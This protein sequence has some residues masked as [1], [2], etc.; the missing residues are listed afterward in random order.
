MNAANHYKLYFVTGPTNGLMPSGHKWLLVSLLIEIYNIIRHHYA[1]MF[2]LI[3]AV[4]SVRS[5]DAIN[6]TLKISLLIVINRMDNES[7]C[8]SHPTLFIRSCKLKANYYWGTASLALLWLLMIWTYIILC[9][10]NEST[11]TIA[12]RWYIFIYVYLVVYQNPIQSMRRTMK[13][14]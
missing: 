1:T 8:T 5:W 11:V 2:F 6:T 3:D 10:T 12:C 9:T 13:P 7:H 4:F 14:H